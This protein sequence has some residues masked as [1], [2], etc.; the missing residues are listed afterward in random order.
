LGLSVVVNFKGVFY[1]AFGSALQVPD[2]MLSWY[3]W[4]L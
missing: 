3:V 2:T 4:E 1:S